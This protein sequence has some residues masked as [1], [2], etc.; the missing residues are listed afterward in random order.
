MPLIKSGSR[1][2]LSQNISEMVRAGHPQK[3]AVAAAYRNAREHGGHFAFGGSVDDNKLS[4][5]AERIRHERYEEM[6]GL[7]WPPEGQASG[8]SFMPG[9][10]AGGSTAPP[11]YV[12][13]EARS[14]GHQG[15]IG[16]IVPGRTDVHHMSVAGGSYV[17]PADTV[18]SIGQGNSL[19]GAAK[20]GQL[21]RSGP[22]GSGAA[23]HISAPRKPISIRQ[24]FADGGDADDGGSA[25]IVTAGG[26]YIV[27]PQTVTKLGGGSLDH[28][29]NV[30]D[31]FVKHVRS[32]TIK[33]LKSLP[34]PKGA[35]K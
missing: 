11:W 25:D 28:G 16:S 3:Q 7:M 12:R 9:Y 8:K 2:A 27:D 26:E 4:K 20:L 15:F 33:K 13:N 6:M 32:H 23:A 34:G 22:Y 35:K 29:H 1:A 14:M 10:A 21:F 19:A 24:K 17:I 5:N 18:S 30:L 31:A